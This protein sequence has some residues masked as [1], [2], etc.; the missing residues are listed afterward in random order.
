MGGDSFSLR[1]VA[2]G[3]TPSVRLLQ[4]YAEYCKYYIPNCNDHVNCSLELVTLYSFFPVVVKF[5][6]SH[7]KILK[8]DPLIGNNLTCYF[9]DKNFVMDSNLEYCSHSTNVSCFPG[10][11]L[12]QALF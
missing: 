2:F 5:F 4:C 9:I 3:V 12:C 6:S 11:I 1:S 7:K 8:N 10:Y